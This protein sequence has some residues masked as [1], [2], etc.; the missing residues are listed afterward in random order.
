MSLKVLT[1]LGT[2][3]EA[4]KLAPIIE[5][6][7]EHRGVESLVCITGQ[8]R[9][10][11]NQMLEFF[12]IRPDY[13]LDIMRPHQDLFDITVNTLVGLRDVLRESK[14]DLVLVQGDT[15]TCLAGAL[16]ANYEGVD[17]GHVEAGLRTGMLSHPYPEELNR[18]LVS[19]I[20]NYHFATTPR[21]L[22]N[23][24]D[25]NVDPGRIW[26]TG[27][28]GIDSLKITV[29]LNRT[30]HPSCWQGVFGDYLCE[31]ILDS[32]RNLM[33]VTLHRRENFACGLDSVCQAVQQLALQYPNLD[34]VLPVH[35]NPNVRRTVIPVLQGH[36]NIHLLEPLAYDA[37]VWLLSKADLVLTD[38][39]GVQEEAP[40]LNVP[41][42]VTRLSTERQESIECGA[43]RLVGLE[44]DAIV[45]QVGELLDTDPAVRDWRAGSPYGD[46]DAARRIVSIIEETKGAN[47]HGRIGT[48]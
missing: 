36:D 31:K 7:G 35:L 4:I 41:T 44:R 1:V 3:P 33:L 30:R 42:F 16:A 12:S 22:Q 17:V 9:H 6:L 47:S 46:G 39:G 8:Q 48:A 29:G 37:F 38:S 32:T 5:L 20:A 25:E 23:L 2:R 14:P 34:V 15:T 11:V 10:L 43:A 13:D 24:V 18:S 26:V 19:R 45:R 27:S 28:T 40:Y 21:A